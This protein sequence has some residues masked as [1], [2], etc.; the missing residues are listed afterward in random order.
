VATERSA[1]RSSRRDQ[2]A[3][4]FGSGLWCAKLIALPKAFQGLHLPRLERRAD[5]RL[6]LG[7]VGAHEGGAGVA[8]R[9]HCSRRHAEQHFQG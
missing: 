7:V 5:R 3:G 1:S 6:A 2:R 4:R 9:S 8:R